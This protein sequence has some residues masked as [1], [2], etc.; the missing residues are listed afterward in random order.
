MAINSFLAL[1]DITG[2]SRDP[3]FADTI[4]VIAWSFGMSQSGTTHL[5][6][7]GGGGK[8]S[9]NDLSITKWIDKVVAHS[10]ASLLRG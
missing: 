9:V 7:G 6:P 3:E 1:G 5:G 10:H 4:D 2:E 8:V